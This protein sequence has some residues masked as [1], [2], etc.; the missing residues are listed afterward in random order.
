MQKLRD[1][2]SFYFA[3][4]T[5]KFQIRQNFSHIKNY[6]IPLKVIRELL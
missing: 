6:K 1:R 4:Q 5:V 3:I 2:K